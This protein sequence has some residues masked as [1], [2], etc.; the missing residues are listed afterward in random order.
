[1]TFAP[2]SQSPFMLR[3]RSMNAAFVLRYLRTNGSR[4]ISAL[5]FV[6]LQLHA[7]CSW[8]FAPLLFGF[9]DLEDLCIQLITVE[10]KG[11]SSVVHF[12][13]QE[14]APEVVRHGVEYLFEFPRLGVIRAVHLLREK[15]DFEHSHNHHSSC[16]A[17]LRGIPLLTLCL[18]D[19]NFP[20]FKN[21]GFVKGPVR[22]SIHLGERI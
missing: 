1:M 16:R 7:P 11:H 18:S 4:L 20:S 8:L 6:C 22:P 15:I 3:Y 10:N 5:I 9:Q 12:K 2:S 14:L 21:D 13:R 19:D 17:V